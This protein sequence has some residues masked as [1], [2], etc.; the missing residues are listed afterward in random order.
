VNKTIRN[1]PRHNFIYNLSSAIPFDFVSHRQADHT[2]VVWTIHYN[3]VNGFD[4][5]SPYIIIECHMFRIT[6]LKHVADKLLIMLCLDTFLYSFIN[7]IFKHNGDALLKNLVWKS[8]R[9]NVELYLSTLWKHIVQGRR[10]YGRRT[11]NRKRHSLLSK[12]FISFARPASLYF[13]IH[14]Y[15]YTYLTVYRLY[16]KYRCYQI[17]LQVKYFYTNQERCEMLTG[18][19]SLGCRSGGDWANTWH[20][21]ERFTVFLWNRK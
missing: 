6:K 20:W 9:C 4:E 18:Y 11:E 17:T 12:F 3:A 5:I 8:Y 16:N 14:L 21:A 1:K 15:I 10:T 7:S 2:I 19:L 13:E